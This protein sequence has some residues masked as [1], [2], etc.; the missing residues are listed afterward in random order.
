M[1]LFVHVG[2]LELCFYSLFVK[3]GSFGV[4]FLFVHVSALEFVFLFV[5]VCDRSFV[6]GRSSLSFVYLYFFFDESSF[7]FFVVRRRSSLAVYHL[8]Y[9]GR[10]SYVVHV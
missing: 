3:V 6:F 8:S 10:R 7:L 9:V 2:E 5:Q 4:M 1:F